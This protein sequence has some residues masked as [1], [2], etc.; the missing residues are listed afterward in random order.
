MDGARLDE[1]VG[2]EG[3]KSIREEVPPPP[4]STHTRPPPSLSPCT[5][6]HLSNP[7]MHALALPPTSPPGGTPHVLGGGSPPPT[8]PAAVSAHAG[9]QVGRQQGRLL[10]TGI[11]HRGLLRR[12]KEAHGRFEDPYKTVSRTCTRT[13]TRIRTRT[14]TRTRARKRTHART[15]T[16]ARTHS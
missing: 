11:V 2:E 10:S 1:G 15:R 14:R 12:K 9:A 13:R 4:P 6:T 7:R 16:C 8:P 5:P 3:L